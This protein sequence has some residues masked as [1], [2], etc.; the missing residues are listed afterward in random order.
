MKRLIAKKEDGIVIK[1]NS[2]DSFPTF[3]GDKFNLS[4]GV[5]EILDIKYCNQ[6]GVEIED[7][8]PEDELKDL[9]P[10]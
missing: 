9:P 3:I 5:V 2:C 10:E 1:L 7:I 8:P 6:F 4:D